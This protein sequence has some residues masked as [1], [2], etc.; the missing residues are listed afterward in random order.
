MEEG[1]GKQEPTG[2]DRVSLA[3]PHTVTPW[4][5]GVEMDGARKAEPFG[6]QHGNPAQERRGGPWKREGR[7]GSPTL[8]SASC[9]RHLG[10]VLGSAVLWAGVLLRKDLSCLSGNGGGFL[11]EARAAASQNPRTLGFRGGFVGRRPLGP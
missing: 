6:F 10:P 7:G 5:E 4:L 1:Q 8:G 9:P 3:G 11:G 2:D